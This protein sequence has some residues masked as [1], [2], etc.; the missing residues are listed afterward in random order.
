MIVDFSPLAGEIVV[1]TPPGGRLFGTTKVAGSPDTA[2]VRRVQIIEAV[3]NAHGHIFPA[4][5]AVVTWVWSDANGEWEVPRLDPTKKYHAI[6]YDHTGVH[7]PVIKTN[8]IP[9]TAP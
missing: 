4:L 9:S 2:A 6:A 1:G 3:P 7:T 5:G 8:L